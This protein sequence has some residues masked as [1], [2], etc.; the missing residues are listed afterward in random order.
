MASILCAVQRHTR[1]SIH[2]HDGLHGSAQ[3]RSEWSTGPE[4]DDPMRSLLRLGPAKL[5]S[6]HHASELAGFENLLDQKC[7]GS[8]PDRFKTPLLLSGPNI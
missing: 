8:N 6:D 1:L 4:M 3:V 2:P 7:Q 5:P